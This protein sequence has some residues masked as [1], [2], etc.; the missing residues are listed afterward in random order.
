MMRQRSR[1]R[2]TTRAP[3]RWCSHRHGEG[4][5]MRIRHLAT[6]AALGALITLVVPTFVVS[7]VAAETCPVGQP[8]GRVPGR[9]GA[10]GQP[11]TDRPAAYPPGA[12]QLQLSASAASAGARVT[13]TGTGFAP[14]SSVD[15]AA[16]A[17]SLG[18]ASADSVGGFTK[19]IVVPA[20]LK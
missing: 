14:A 12:C 1:A 3:R 8:P 18:R 15:L 4:G 5:S 16:G 9:S 2:R 7:A 19:V 20:S 6:G 13:V 11:S 17:A 10:N